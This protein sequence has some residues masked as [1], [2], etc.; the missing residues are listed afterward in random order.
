[1]LKV[2]G[3]TRRQLGATVRWQAGSTVLVGLVIGVP[4]GVI[5]GRVLWRAFAGQL[6]VVSQPST[7]YVAILAVSVL[8]VVV[9]L[10]AAAIPAQVARRVKAATVLHSE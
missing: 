9:A 4:L 2:L 5:T 6:A 1:L 8:A 7:P 3:F 10:I